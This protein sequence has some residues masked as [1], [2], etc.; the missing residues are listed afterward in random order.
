MTTHILLK[1]HEEKQFFEI[2]GL[3]EFLRLQ[4]EKDVWMQPIIAET[5]I[6]DIPN[7]PNLQP[8]FISR[9]NLNCTEDEFRENMLDTGIIIAI[10]GDSSKN[11]LFVRDT[12]YASLCDRS[13]L[14]GPSLSKSFKTSKEHFSKILNLGLQLWTEKKGK[15]LIRDGKVS[16]FHSNEYVPLPAYDLVNRLERGLSGDFPGSEFKEAM[17]THS[18]LRARYEFPRQKDDILSS[19]NRALKRKGKPPVTGMPVLELCSSDV[20]TSG[21][22]IYTGLYTDDGY[23]R[24]GADLKVKHKGDATLADFDDNAAKVY[25]LFKDASKKLEELEAI[26]MMYPTD[27][28]LHIAHDQLLPKRASEE[29][30]DEFDINRPIKCS[31][32]DVY[33]ALWNIDVKAEQTATPSELRLQEQIARALRLDFKKY[34]R[35]YTWQNIKSA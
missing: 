11:Y 7:C 4:K 35:P 34:D 16:A 6:M 28:F 17:L 22:N 20:A 25:S 15:L 27:A 8:E 23:I 10:P 32:L 14:K 31:A 13:G 19:L 33:F 30:A 9:Y 21:A 26:P 24:T 5:S 3:L 18:M 2:K 29:A 12:A 1:D